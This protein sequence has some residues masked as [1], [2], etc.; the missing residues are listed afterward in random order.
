MS[1]PSVLPW[2]K[3]GERTLE[4]LLQ[5]HWPQSWG[6]HH[7]NHL[8][9]AAPLNAVTLGVHISTWEFLKHVY[10]NIVDLQCYVSFFCTGKWKLHIYIHPLS[11]LTP[12][13]PTLGFLLFWED[14]KKKC[15]YRFLEHLPLCLCVTHPLTLFGFL[16]QCHLLRK[17]FP[18]TL[19]EWQ[20]PCLL[21]HLPLLFLFLGLSPSNIKVYI[22]FVHF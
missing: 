22:F 5:Q 7:Y 10:Q 6:V 19:R 21:W 1:S 15:L 13:F 18:E 16:L 3:G 12:P 20:Q 11:V 2:W 17:V 14:K 4:G 8:P 9:E